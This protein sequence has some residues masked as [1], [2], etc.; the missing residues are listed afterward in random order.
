MSIS[1]PFENIPWLTGNFISSGKTPQKLFSE[2][3]R[4]KLSQPASQANTKLAKTN[5]FLSTEENPNELGESESG[6]VFE[7][8]T[9]HD[10]FVKPTYANIESESGGTESETLETAETDESSGDDEGSDISR[11]IRKYGIIGANINTNEKRKLAV[12]SASSAAGFPHNKETNPDCAS[13]ND[14]LCK[15]ESF[16]RR[17]RETRVPPKEYGA[18][19]SD[20]NRQT[21]RS[22]ERRTRSDLKNDGFITSYEGYEDNEAS[23]ESSSDSSER[24]VDYYGRHYENS[25]TLDQDKRVDAAGNGMPDKWDS[26]IKGTSQE[27]ADRKRRERPTEADNNSN[28]VREEMRLLSLEDIDLSH[29]KVTEIPKALLQLESLKS[30]RL[31]GMHFLNRFWFLLKMFCILYGCNIEKP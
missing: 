8:P 13:S 23:S 14:N 7:A 19:K 1:I 28:A 2:I 21:R 22:D 17:S 11:P 5:S 12:I 3:H 25:R 20:N 4:G 30:L 16:L 6:S 31:S 24:R 29:N 10:I 18:Q 26:N 15:G 27:G 9:V